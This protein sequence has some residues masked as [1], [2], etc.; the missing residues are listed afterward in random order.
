[1]NNIFMQEDPKV[2]HANLLHVLRG[3]FAN[4]ID[5]WPR[6]PLGSKSSGVQ[7]KSTEPWGM[8]LLAQGR[9]T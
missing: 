8:A 1:M 2:S 3:Q 6:K 7:W 4:P 9:L 5:Q